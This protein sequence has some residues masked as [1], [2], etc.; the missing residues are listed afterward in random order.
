MPPKIPILTGPTATGKTRLGVE[1]AL[2][3]GGEI[4]SADSMQVYRG[5]DIGTAKATAAERRGVPHH[6]LDVADPTEPYSAARYAREAGACVADI[7]RRGRVPIVVGG[8]GL[9]INALLMGDAFAPIPADGALRAALSAE[10]DAMGG[11]AFR[12]KLAQVD[13][14]RAQR[15]QPGDKKRLVRA[16]EVYRLTGRT[17]TEFD[18]ESRARP[19]AYEG[20]KIA[21]TFA[22]RAQLYGRID[23]RVSAMFRDGLVAEVRALLDAG[24]PPEST[25]MQAI[26]YKELADFLAGQGTLAEA[27]EAIARAS[28]RYAKRQLTWLRREKDV[29]WL[30]WEGEP[31]FDWA[32]R[33]STAFFH[34]HG[35]K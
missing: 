34:S 5:M 20:V 7:L 23:A 1:L 24:V 26:G 33:L 4:V 31:D 19:P 2:A 22:D 9:Y 16:M 11:A 30:Q 21:L 3:L 13:A 25:A 15:L 28:R 32:R 29:F 27:E 18:V 8:T 35:I 6:M 12:E 10:Y 17:L 14:Q